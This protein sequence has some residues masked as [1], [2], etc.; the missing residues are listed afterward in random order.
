MRGIGGHSGSVGMGEWGAWQRGLSRDHGTAVRKMK[1]LTAG[2]SCQ[3][4]ERRL[5]IR[6]SGWAMPVGPDWA[7]SVHFSFPFFLLS[8]ILFCFLK[9]FVSFA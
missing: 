8:F 6:D 2:P 9:S 5:P 1:D 4:G 3:G 7:V